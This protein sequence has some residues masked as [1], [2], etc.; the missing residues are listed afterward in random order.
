MGTK[1]AKDAVKLMPVEPAKRPVAVIF[2]LETVVLNYRAILFQ[3]LSK[4]LK[5][6]GVKLSIGMFI[7][8]CLYRSPQ[9]FIEPLLTSAGK[10]LS[11][12][13]FKTE[14]IELLQS[15]FKHAALPP[16]FKKLTLALTDQAVSVG[17]I[18]HLPKEIF[19]AMAPLTGQSLPQRRPGRSAQPSP[20]GRPTDLHHAFTV[21][22][23]LLPRLGHCP[24]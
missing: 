3:A 7:K 17:C 16:E 20:R 10:R 18:H 13:K 12:D 23:C 2:E 19:D 21:F 8:H 11:P 1:K 5:E 4:Q 22:Q 15:E 14:L 9:Q 24:A 6:K